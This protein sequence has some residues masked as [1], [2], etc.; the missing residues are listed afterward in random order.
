MYDE[1]VL[2]CYRFQE[3]PNPRRYGFGDAV[4][5]MRAWPMSG[6]DIT[7][8]RETVAASFTRQGYGPTNVS[9]LGFTR[10]APTTGGAREGSDVQP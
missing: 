10:L 8:T 6:D 1:Q 2:V 5:S 7:E 3:E 4:V 9:F